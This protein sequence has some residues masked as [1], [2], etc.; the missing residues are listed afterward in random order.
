MNT[1][2]AGLFIFIMFI[3]VA[4]HVLTKIIDPVHEQASRPPDPRL[5]LEGKRQKKTSPR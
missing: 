4:H 3:L 5:P 1:I 2:L